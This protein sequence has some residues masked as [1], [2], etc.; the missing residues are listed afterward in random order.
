MLSNDWRDSYQNSLAHSKFSITFNVTCAR[1][2][3][4]P[5]FSYICNLFNMHRVGIGNILMILNHCVHYIHMRTEYK[6]H[7]NKNYLKMSNC[8]CTRVFFCNSFFT[9]SSKFLNKY[10]H[11]HTDHKWSFIILFPKWVFYINLNKNIIPS[12]HLTCIV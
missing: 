4:L 9:T 5:T 3:R 8:K 12:L 1:C 6:N 2:A 10:T 11:H 7:I